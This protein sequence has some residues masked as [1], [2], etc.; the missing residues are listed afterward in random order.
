VSKDTKFEFGT[1]ISDGYTEP[2]RIHPKQE[3]NAAGNDENRSVPNNK[4]TKAVLWKFGSVN[5]I[6]ENLSR[7]IGSNERRWRWPVIDGWTKDSNDLDAKRCTTW[8][9]DLSL[10]RNY[11]INQKSGLTRSTN[12][13]LNASRKVV[14][15]H[16]F[17]T[18]NLSRLV[19]VLRNNKLRWF[20][21]PS[22]R[23]G[24]D[25]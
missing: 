18:P 2:I 14:K 3:L 21:T 10:Y 4:S 8:P 25:H 1:G 11:G 12:E 24:R 23:L 19:V 7:T 15:S 16:L 20:R 9:I 13:D 5:A 22:V 6:C 17:A